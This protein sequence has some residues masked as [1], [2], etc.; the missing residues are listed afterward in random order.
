VLSG[1]RQFSS[2]VISG[3]SIYWQTFH[4]Y[5]SCPVQQS[6]DS[7]KKK[8]QQWW[9]YLAKTA[10]PQSRLQSAGTTRRNARRSSLCLSQQSKDQQRGKTY[11]CCPANSISKPSSASIT[12]KFHLYPL[13]IT[14]PPRVLPQQ[15]S[16]L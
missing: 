8:N 16:F 11:K 13:N 7:K 6:Q 3:S 12:R 1:N 4:G 5:I 15:E 14:C 2:Q 9:H 10:R